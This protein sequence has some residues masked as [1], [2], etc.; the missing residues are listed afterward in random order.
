MFE[1]VETRTF[2]T[3]EKVIAKYMQHLNK[4]HATSK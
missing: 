4:T 1:T 3:L 2:E